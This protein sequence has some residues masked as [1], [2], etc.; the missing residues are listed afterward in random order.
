MAEPMTIATPSQAQPLSTAARI[1]LILPKKPMVAGKP[2]SES[3]AIVIG[4]ASQGFSAPSPRS[5]ARSSPA[6]VERSRATIT[7]KAAMFIST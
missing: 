3:M 6:P 4:H 2:A 5:A 7:A 1:R